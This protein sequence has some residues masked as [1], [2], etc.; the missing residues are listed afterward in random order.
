VVAAEDLRA[1]FAV[2]GTVLDCKVM[3]DKVTG[4][5]RQIGFVRFGSVADATRALEEMTGK[6]LTSKVDPTDESQTPNVSLPLVS[7]C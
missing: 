4:L 3:V 7:T 5:S 2:F 6:V 1:I